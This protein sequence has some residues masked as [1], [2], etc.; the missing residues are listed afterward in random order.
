MTCLIDASSGGPLTGYPL[1]TLTVMSTSKTAA[2]T[3][4]PAG[5]GCSSV[6]RANAAR[7]SAAAT[8]ATRPKPARS[9]APGSCVKCG[10]PKKRGQGQRLCEKCAEVYAPTRCHGCGT[11]EKPKRR[12]YCDECRALREAASDIR[13]RER[14][15]MR[16]VK[17]CRGCGGV[18]ERGRRVTYCARCRR[19]REQAR[20]MTCTRCRMKPA[21]SKYAHLCVD[22]RL[23][24]DEDVREYKRQWEKSNPRP[25]GQ[26]RSPQTRM[27]IRK[28]KQIDNGR[29]LE[30]A[31]PIQTTNGRRVDSDSFPSLPSGPMIAALDRLFLKQHNAWVPVIKDTSGKVLPLPGRKAMCERLCLSERALTRWRAGERIAFDTAD[32]ILQTVEWLW[33]DVWDEPRAPAGHG[34]PR[35]V[36]AFIDAV[37]GYEIVRDAF[38][39]T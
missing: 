20:V 7:S 12:Q 11:T 8:T 2:A 10:K 15:R 34:C 30:P 22:C 5:S 27:I 38:T 3:A 35:D 21:R 23:L 29:T 19:E 37:W 1:T 24:A 36:L 6:T 31:P 16:F 33:F 25:G 32:R 13:K 14:E 18:K 39:S 28:L 4:S 9:A 26:K 17:P